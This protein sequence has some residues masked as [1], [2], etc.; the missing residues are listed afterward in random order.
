VKSRAEKLA[1]P[2]TFSALDFTAARMK[3]VVIGGYPMPTNY[4]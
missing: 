4:Y 1:S 2:I 3:I